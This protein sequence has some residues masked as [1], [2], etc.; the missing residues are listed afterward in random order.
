MTPKQMPLWGRPPRA[1]SYDQ[2]VARRTAE[3]N[4]RELEIRLERERERQKQEYEEAEEKRLNDEAKAREAVLK[5]ARLAEEER[6]QAAKNRR[7]R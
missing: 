6:K 7:K 2:F 5:A 1:E 3:N 4:A